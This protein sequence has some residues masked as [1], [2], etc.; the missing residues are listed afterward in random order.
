MTKKPN[1]IS[2]ADAVSAGSSVAEEFIN[3]APD[4]KKPTQSD[5]L[6]RVAF[7]I[8]PKVRSQLKMIANV[9]GITFRELIMSYIDQEI[10][11]PG[12]WNDI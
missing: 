3:G 9:R 4:V 5:E 8:P 7:Q 10:A 11:K 12:P 1:K 6:V 2:I